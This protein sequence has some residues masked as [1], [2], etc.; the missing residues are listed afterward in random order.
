LFLPITEK[1]KKVSVINVKK[2]QLPN[3]TNLLREMQSLGSS[4]NH[5]SNLVNTMLNTFDMTIGEYNSI[6]I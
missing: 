5:Q 1:A 2:L 6:E 4:S 3:N